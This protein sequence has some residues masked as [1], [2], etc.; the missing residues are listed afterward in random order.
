VYVCARACV[1]ACVRAR[2][3]GRV[4]VVK[5]LVSRPGIRVPRH[6]VGAL[7]DRARARPTG[8][9]GNAFVF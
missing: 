4:G 7:I 6:N 9:E 1:R 5:T 8:T 2:G 3:L